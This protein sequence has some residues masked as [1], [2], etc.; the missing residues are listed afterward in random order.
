MTLS[1]FKDLISQSP[2]KDSYRNIEFQL[3]LAHLDTTINLKGGINIYDFILRQIDGFNKWDNLPT[4]LKNVKDRFS[5]ISNSIAEAVT[6]SH[7]LYEIEKSLARLNTNNRNIFLSDSPETEFLMNIHLNRPLCYKGAFQYLTGSINSSF[8]KNQL[9]GWIMAYEFCNKDSDI[10]DRRQAEESSL[11]KIRS[12]SQKFLQDSQIDFSSFVEKTISQYNKQ[13]DIIT[14]SQIE[15]NTSY[16]QWF[17]GTS[18]LFSEFEQS[19]KDNIKELENLYQQK[20]KL[21]APAAYWNNRANKLRKDGHK[22]LIILSLIIVFGISI[23]IWVLNRIADGTIDR[24]FDS[25]ATAIKWSV[26]LITMISFIAYGIR[27]FSKLAFS[28]FH[29]VR[30][31]EEREQLTY[32]Y[33]ALQK[34]KGIDQT[35]R[36][37]IMQSLF[38]R[39]DSGLLRDEGGP[40]MPGH[41]VDQITKR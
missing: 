31:A 18:T 6:N 5:S 12:D 26:V 8:D 1:E 33:L 27:V 25:S 34:E 24:I 17:T 15:Q 2:L 22:W 35:E 37:L 7:P 28:T 21:E 40:T 30:D 19:A 3:K 39:A 29:L 38:S 10:T 32:V 9:E 23:L 16:K 11:E 4:E 13:T 14:R 36:H 41:I 20:L